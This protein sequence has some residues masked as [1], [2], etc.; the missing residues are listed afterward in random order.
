MISDPTALQQIRDSWETVRESE[1][2]ASLTMVKAFMSGIPAGTAPAQLFWRLLLIFAYSV[3][4]D[5]LLELRD[6]G[7]FASRKS[8]LKELMDRSKA[9]LAWLNF[10]LADEGRERRNDVAH[11]RMQFSPDQCQ[12]YIRCVEAELKQWAI[13]V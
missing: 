2:A 3:F 13:L 9:A 10:P 1:K 11:R 7:T 5:A 12:R 8:N 6:Q 4:E